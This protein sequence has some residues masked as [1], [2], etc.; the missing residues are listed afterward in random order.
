[1]CGRPAGQR[2]CGFVNEEQYFFT[3]G[4][5]CY[6]EFFPADQLTQS[7]RFTHAIE[8]NNGRQ[9]HW[10]AQ[11]RRRSIVV[12]KSLDS[13]HRALA[14]FARFRIN[15]DICELTALLR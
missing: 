6:K 13:L 11:F 4:Y 8:R 7:K 9:R 1:M 12:S 14:L 15:G 10:L 2:G 3:D 5:E